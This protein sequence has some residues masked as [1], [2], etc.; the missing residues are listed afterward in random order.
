MGQD[1]EKRLR[2]KSNGGWK[3]EFARSAGIRESKCRDLRL[4]NKEDAE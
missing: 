1:P 2:S 3:T 4:E